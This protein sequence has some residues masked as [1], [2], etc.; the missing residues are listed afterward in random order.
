MI[1]I[2]RATAKRTGKFKREPEKIERYESTELFTMITQRLKEFRNSKRNS[3]SKKISRE[4]AFT[5]RSRSN[6]QSFCNNISTSSWM[7]C[8]IPI[9]EKFY[10]ITGNIFGLISP[11]F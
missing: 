8:E 5:T 10:N 1:Y 11:S 3:W 7:K 9:V 2:I 6:N 4:L